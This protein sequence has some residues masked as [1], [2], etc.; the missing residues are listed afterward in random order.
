MK[1]IHAIKVQAFRNFLE[2]GLSQKKSKPFLCD[3][4]N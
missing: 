1:F 3:D 2:A 4:P